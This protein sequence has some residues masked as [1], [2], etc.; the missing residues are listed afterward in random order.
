[1]EM[2]GGTRE[3]KRQA[4]ELT[5]LCKKAYLKQS[6]E[7]KMRGTNTLDLLFGLV[8]SYETIITELSDHRLI[9][10][11]TTGI[12]TSESLQQIPPKEHTI[13][14]SDLNFYRNDIE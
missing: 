12:K 4:E 3:E 7:D 8:H 1:M 13:T 9:K 5:D 14:L 11:M 6:I 2:T 10:V